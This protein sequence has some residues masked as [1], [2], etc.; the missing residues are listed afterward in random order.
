MNLKKIILCIVIVLTL[1]ISAC[2]SENLDT[3]LNAAYKDKLTVAVSI[4]PEETFV[5][6]VAGDLIDV[7]T[8]IPPGH[9][10][11]NYEP[12]PGQMLKFSKSKI[13]F[14]M[15]V[16]TEEANILPKI[17]SLNKDIKVVSLSEKVKEFYPERSFAK[18]RDPHI[19]LSPKR[20]KVMIE[21]IKDELIELDPNNKS[22]Y[23][24]NAEEY[25]LKLDNVNSEIKEILN[26]V[27]QQS[28]IIYHPAFGYF[29]DDYGLI[30]VPIEEVGK[31]AT[32][33][34]LQD[35]IDF[36]NKENIK[37]I[38]YQD[39][40]DSQQADTVAEEING[41]TINVSP[42]ASNYIDNLREIANKFSEKLNN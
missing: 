13:Y 31:E 1:I 10:P 26:D 30:M 2:K 36:A 17:D 4:V 42:L 14:S 32:S 25:K 41:T 16:P 22:V 21:V 18:G 29:A 12:T 9:S 40:F 23:E 24:K 20:V 11:A 15:G 27:K 37:Y 34:R 38:L 5:T 7:I 19:W 35:I 28:F 8:M 33:K 6:A 3:S 39:E